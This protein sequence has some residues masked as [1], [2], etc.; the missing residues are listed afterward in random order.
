MDKKIIQA[1]NALYGTVEVEPKLTRPDAQFGDYSTNVAMQL[2]AKLGKNPREIAEQLAIS[3]ADA[4]T[5]EELTE[6]THT[7]DRYLMNMYYF[8]PMFYDNTSRFAYWVNNIT[9]P[10]INQKIGTNLM[11][12]GWKPQVA[13]APTTACATNGIFCRIKAFVK[14]LF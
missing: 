6:R 14:S 2:A 10:E 3:L 4:K 9:F 1:V 13:A 7:L 8:I 5:P 12:Y 11:A